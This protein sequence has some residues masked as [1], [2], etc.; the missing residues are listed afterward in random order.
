MHGVKPYY[1]MKKSKLQHSRPVTRLFE[2][3]RQNNQVGEDY[4]PLYHLFLLSLL[5][6]VATQQ[7]QLKALLK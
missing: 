4:S 1:V 2:G 6:S 7:S 3:G 5:P